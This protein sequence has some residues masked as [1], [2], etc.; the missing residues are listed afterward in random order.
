MRRLLLCTSLV[1]ECR[2]SG[3]QH[4]S[5]LDVADIPVVVNGL[6]PYTVPLDQNLPSPPNTGPV[7]V[8][9]ILFVANGITTKDDT[10][11]VFAWS[12]PSSADCNTNIVSQIVSCGL[13]NG[14]LQYLNTR[15]IQYIPRNFSHDL[16][17]STTQCTATL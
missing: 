11:T 4:V 9:M 10:G 3:S 17:P 7:L 1:Y 13:W 14:S 5:V 2:N 15:R 6:L 8:V 16:S 12:P